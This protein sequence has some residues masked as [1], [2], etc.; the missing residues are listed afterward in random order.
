MFGGT[1]SVARLGVFMVVWWLV[2]SVIRVSC[3]Y[4]SGRDLTGDRSTNATFLDDGTQR[5]GQP[6]YWGHREPTRWAKLAGWKR[7]TIRLVVPPVLAGL[8]V[9]WLLW[10]TVTQWTGY[11]VA[12]VVLGW[13]VAYV[14]RTVSNAPHQLKYVRPLHKALGSRLPLDE[15]WKPADWLHIPQDFREDPDTVITIELPD[16]FHGGDPNEETRQSARAAF[17]AVVYEKLGLRSGEWIAN[18]HM[19]GEEPYVEYRKSAPVPTEVTFADVAVVVKSAKDDAP[20]I[21]LG[22][23]KKPVSVDLDA[24][25]PHT[26]VSMAPG[27]GKSTLLR[28]LAAQLLANDARVIILDIKRSFPLR[29]FRDHPH[30]RYR[31]HPAD[32]HDEL[33]ALPVELKRRVSVYDKLP[34]DAEQPSVEQL[35]QLMGPRIAVFVEEGNALVAELREQ[36]SQLR[37]D[38]DGKTPDK[39]PAFSALSSTLNMGR[40]P[41]MNL[42]IVAQQGTAE[43]TGGGAGR[44]SVSNRILAGWTKNTWM[45]LAPEVAM[46]AKSERMGRAQMVRAGKIREV[47]TINWTTTE[48]REWAWSCFPEGLGV[49]DVAPVPREAFY[50]GFSGLSDADETFDVTALERESTITRTLESGPDARLALPAQRAPEEATSPASTA[51]DAADAAE[52]AE[53]LVTLKEAAERGLVELSDTPERTWHILRRNS[54]KDRDGA[55]FA[56]RRGRRGTAY[57]YRPS[58]LQQWARNRPKA[59]V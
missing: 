11:V 55:N 21:G 36:W 5:H 20:V 53:E 35:K 1:R 12:G 6:A 19:I 24:D 33:M 44:E 13:L 41:L 39:S 27:Y 49:A 54:G 51:A 3:R 42:F 17:N 34:P 16:T 26:L 52:D 32:I 37:A 30:V 2:K 45:M 25:S 59:S 56:P 23:G 29:L 22:R 43:V 7:A 58:E 8:A 28:S 46:P 31:T 57:L 40:E 15:A 4:V 18:Y 9:A 48:A 14:I 38:I 50:Q 47:Q 10:P